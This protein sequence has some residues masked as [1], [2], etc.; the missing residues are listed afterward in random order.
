LKQE[1]KSRTSPGISSDVTAPTF[2]ISS[3]LTCMAITTAHGNPRSDAVGTDFIR[4]IWIGYDW[5]LSWSSLLRGSLTSMTSSGTSSQW[6]KV[7][8]TTLCMH[9]DGRCAHWQGV[10]P[11]VDKKSHVAHTP[12]RDT[13]GNTPSYA[14]EHTHIR[15]RTVQEQ[16]GLFWST[17]EL[18]RSCVLSVAGGLDWSLAVHHFR[19]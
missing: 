14:H 12:S 8:G 5:P 9:K 17:M 13:C 4:R 10:N 6:H 16:A 11:V 2:C 15:K 18:G 1:H 3:F 19:P 7:L